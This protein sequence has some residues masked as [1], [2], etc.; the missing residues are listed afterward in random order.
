MRDGNQQIIFEPRQV[1]GWMGAHAAAN[2]QNPALRLARLAA[3]CTGRKI[4]DGSMYRAAPRSEDRGVNS[5]PLHRRLQIFTQFALEIEASEKPVL[6]RVS[7]PEMQPSVLHSAA[8]Q[9]T[10]MSRSTLWYRSDLLMDP[11]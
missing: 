1:G 9:G 8:I 3:R 7:W 2:A 6:E 10:Y 11:L 4:A 5:H